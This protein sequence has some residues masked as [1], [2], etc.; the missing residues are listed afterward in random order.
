MHGTIGLKD[1]IKFRRFVRFPKEVVINC[2][3][4][5]TRGT[6]P[7]LMH[8]RLDVL[9]ID[10]VHRFHLLS[11]EREVVRQLSNWNRPAPDA[12]HRG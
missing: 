2:A 1:G 10:F 3:I 5:R 8:R 7:K 11:G 9:C 4:Y 6:L 12:K